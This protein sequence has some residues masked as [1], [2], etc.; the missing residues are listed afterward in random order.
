MTTKGVVA[1]ALTQGG[2][3]G[4]VGEALKAAAEKKKAQS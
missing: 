4:S 2:S 3:I 1:M